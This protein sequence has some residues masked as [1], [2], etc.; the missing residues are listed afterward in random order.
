MIRPYS[1]TPKILNLVSVISHI[2]GKLDSIAFK[3]PELKLRRK[4][5]IRTIKATLAIEGNTFTEV[6]ITAILENKKV[7]G[8]KKEI[9]EVQNAI[10]L[11]ENI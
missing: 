6:Q 2:L 9:I 4:N 1:L 5:R 3:T 11:Y 10:K 8:N 7:I